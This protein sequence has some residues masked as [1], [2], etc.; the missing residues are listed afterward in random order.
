MNPKLIFMKNIILKIAFLLF[1]FILTIGCSVEQEDAPE[2]ELITAKIFGDQTVICIDPSLNTE[3]YCIE[4]IFVEYEPRV[5]IEEKQLI[6]DPYCGDMIAIKPCY[7]NPNIEIWTVR[8]NPDCAKEPV[9]L[10]PTDPDLRQSTVSSS[11]YQFFRQCEN[12]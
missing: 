5:S 3:G 1:T 8:G 4:Y 12:L 10:P 2:Q 6:R 7:N 11:S 9:L